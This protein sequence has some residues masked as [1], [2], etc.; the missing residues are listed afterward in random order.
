LRS[1]F[2]TDGSLKSNLRVF[3]PLFLVTFAIKI[4]LFFIVDRNH[5]DFF[6]VSGES[7]QKFNFIDKFRSSVVT[8]PILEE[9][10][11]RYPALIAYHYSKVRFKF[12]FATIL[13]VS[14]VL[15]AMVHSPTQ[16][17]FPISQFIGGLT[18]FYIGSRSNIFYC[19]AFHMFNNF[20]ALLLETFFGM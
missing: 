12:S 20:L 1:W 5:I 15:F 19:I 14:S 11:F 3:V 6:F 13:I 16:P 7:A 4:L 18:Y 9:Y 17:R 8:S 10:I 2:E